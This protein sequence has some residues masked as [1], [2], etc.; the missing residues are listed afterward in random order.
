[1]FASIVD[2]SIGMLPYTNPRIEIHD[3]VM[4]IFVKAPLKM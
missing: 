4:D 2:G 1:M 3:I